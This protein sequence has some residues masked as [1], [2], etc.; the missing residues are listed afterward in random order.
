[1]KK[2]FVRTILT[3][4]TAVVLTVGFAA[5]QEH[6]WAGRALDNVEWAV[7]E[8]LAVLPSYGVFDTIR[9]ETEG[10]MV[11]LSGSVVKEDVKDNAE[12][13]VKQVAGV[14]KVVNNIEVLPSSR[15][16]DALRIN[17][18]RAIYAEQALDNYGRG[19]ASPVHIIV[20][21]GWAT[22][23]GVVGSDAERNSIRNR[24]LKVTAH[25]F[26][27]LRVARAGL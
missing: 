5:A 1:M 8:K 22:L 23:E 3:A 16:D 18:Y 10:S 6:K 13:A 21:N 15:G 11:T 12:R 7:H 20:K 9:F 14:H 2:N 27:N 24:A 4:A 25:L 19:Q 17:L 26:D